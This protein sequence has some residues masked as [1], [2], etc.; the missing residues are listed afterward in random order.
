M[1]PQRLLLVFG[2]LLGSACSAADEQPPPRTVQSE[3]GALEAEL[4]PHTAVTRGSNQLSLWVRDASSGTNIGD[5]E[6]AM[7]PFMPAMGHGSGVEPSVKPLGNGEYVFSGVVL[8][9]AGRW[10][11]RT[12]VSGPRS[13]YVAFDVDVP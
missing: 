7:V 10:Q 9:M 2:L 4:V 1:L 12:T 6:L 5:L 8:N 11:L 3:S 13:D